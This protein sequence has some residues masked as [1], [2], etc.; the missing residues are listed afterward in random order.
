LS[1]FKFSGIVGPKLSTPLANG[2]IG[3]RDATFGKQLFDF[4]EAQAKTMVQPDGMANNFGGES[5]TLVGEYI[6]F[7]M[8]PS[9]P[10]AR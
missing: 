9:L 2:F 6:G 7:F 4:T 8:R 10:N 1:F 3:D 5:V